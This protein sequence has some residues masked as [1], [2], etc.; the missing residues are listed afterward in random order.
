ML[1]LLVTKSTMLPVG[2]IITVSMTCTKPLEAVRSKLMIL[3]PS[4]VNIYQKPHM[5]L[6]YSRLLSFTH[7][8]MYTFE[9]KNEN[10]YMIMSIIVQSMFGSSQ[11]SSWRSLYASGLWME[12]LTMWYFRIFTKAVVLL[13][14]RSRTDWG[15]SEKAALVGANIV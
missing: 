1:L 10:T 12:P 14:R 2:G 9:R 15:S 3:D 13:C 7:Y 4:T 6:S 5:Y 11:V 8:C